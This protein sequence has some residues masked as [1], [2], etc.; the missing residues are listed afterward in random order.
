MTL[1]IS[2]IKRAVW[3]G[4]QALLVG[5]NITMTVVSALRSGKKRTE[6]YIS[7]VEAAISGNPTSMDVTDWFLKRLEEILKVSSCRISMMPMLK[8]NLLSKRCGW[9]RRLYEDAANDESGYWS[10][11]LDG[12]VGQT[13]NDVAKYADY[14]DKNRLNENALKLGQKIAAKGPLDKLAHEKL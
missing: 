12:L 14:D 3:H 7:D 10:L 9:K 6:N 4:V 1:G 2:D 13:S 8:K 5:A 11:G